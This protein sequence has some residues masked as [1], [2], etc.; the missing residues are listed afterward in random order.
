MASY[1]Y[2][3][4]DSIYSKSRSSQEAVDWNSLQTEFSPTTHGN[5]GWMLVRLSA[6]VFCS[7][8]LYLFAGMG[9]GLAALLA[10]W[11]VLYRR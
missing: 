4:R 5:L 11:F 6:I 9:A 2:S 8:G 1:T 3:M 7:L 10:G